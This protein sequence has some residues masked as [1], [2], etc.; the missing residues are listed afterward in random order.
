MMCQ[1]TT[2]PDTF[3]FIDGEGDPITLK[4]PTYDNET[5]Y[6]SACNQ[7]MT[8]ADA[9]YCCEYCGAFEEYEDDEDE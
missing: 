2:V 4:R 7:P 8:E 9:G 6:C 3:E 5:V 1:G